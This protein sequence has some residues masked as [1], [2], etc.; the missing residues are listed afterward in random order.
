M[1]DLSERKRLAEN[2]RKDCSVSYW[3]V[4]WAVRRN[5]RRVCCGSR[6]TNGSL[7]MNQLV[8]PQRILSGNTESTKNSRS[9]FHARKWLVDT[10][11]FKSMSKQQER[12]Q[13]VQ[14]RALQ[15]RHIKELLEGDQEKIKDSTTSSDDRFTMEGLSRL[16]ND[17]DTNKN[18]VLEVNELQSALEKLG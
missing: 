16:F 9:S 17:L 4:E 7:L 15:Q 12:E 3:C 2:R 8:L 14:A 6:T 1:I 10:G 13:R 5:Y 11:N 18:G